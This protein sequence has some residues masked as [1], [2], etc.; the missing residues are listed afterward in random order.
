MW[1]ERGDIIL[2]QDSCHTWA[3]KEK[4]KL[5]GNIVA[6]LELKER[7]ERISSQ[8]SCQNSAEREER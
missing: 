8:D 1:A 7:E 2:L 4:W 3:E 6:T 5:C